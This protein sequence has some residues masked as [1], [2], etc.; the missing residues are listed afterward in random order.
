MRMF[1]GELRLCDVV[2]KLMKAR[3]RICT[4][5]QLEAKQ[6]KSMGTEDLTALAS[7]LRRGN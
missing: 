6:D 3:D 1:C 5:P 7:P 4:L 2:T